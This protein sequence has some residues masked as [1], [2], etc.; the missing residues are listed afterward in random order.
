VA[1]ANSAIRVLASR[2]KK[3]FGPQHQESTA[4]V[5]MR[6]QRLVQINGNQLSVLFIRGEF[7]DRN[8]RFFGEFEGAAE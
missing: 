8:T 2:F 1:F 5:R 4:E 7:L 6:S 3:V